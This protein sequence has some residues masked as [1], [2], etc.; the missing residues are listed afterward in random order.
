[1]TYKINLE[2]M[3]KELEELKFQIKSAFFLD[4]ESPIKLSHLIHHVVGIIEQEYDTHLVYVYTKSSIVSDFRDAQNEI[5]NFKFHKDENKRYRLQREAFQKAQKEALSA[6]DNLSLA[7]K[8]GGLI[9][10]AST[11]S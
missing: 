8:D 1:M 5:N 4:W 9:L 3:T 7:I 10:K 2:K 11:Q 6:F